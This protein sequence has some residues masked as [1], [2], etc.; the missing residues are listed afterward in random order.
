MRRALYSI[1]RRSLYWFV[2]KSFENSSRLLKS[3]VRKPFFLSVCVSC[4]QAGSEGG[5]DMCRREPRGRRG[6][7][8]V[9]A[10][11]SNA[12]DGQWSAWREQRTAYLWVSTYWTPS[13]THLCWGSKYEV[14]YL[15]VFVWAIANCL[16]TSASR[17]G[18]LT[19]YERGLSCGTGTGGREAGCC[20][21][22]QVAARERIT[23]SHAAVPLSSN[24][25]I[26]ETP[27]AHAHAETQRGRTSDQGPRASQP[28]QQCLP[29]A[30]SCAPSPAVRRRGVY[31]VFM[32]QMKYSRPGAAEVPEIAPFRQCRYSWWS[33]THRG[34]RAPCS[35]CC[36]CLER[37]LSARESRC[38]PCDCKLSRL[39]PQLEVET[40]PASAAPITSLGLS[41]CD[42]ARR[43]VG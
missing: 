17:F 39:P 4:A 27:A 25:I 26:M 19:G 8:E 13:M 22:A 11:H 16:P 21:K 31:N 43:R 36:S 24:K 1:F 18:S 2:A 33:R 38:F 40:R 23:S 34:A 42:G 3:L 30:W 14:G 41:D 9:V 12:T 10:S 35:G 32:L 20:Q 5:E 29:G 7:S 37:R 28:S 6:R 15:P